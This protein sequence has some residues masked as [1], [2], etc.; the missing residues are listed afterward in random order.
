LETHNRPRVLETGLGDILAAEH[1]GYTGS[2]RRF[3]DVDPDDLGVGAVG[4]QEVSEQLPG[5]LPVRRIAAASGDQTE[6]LAAA[7]EPFSHGC[8]LRCS[9]RRGE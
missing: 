4:A 1:A 6:I 3:G 9:F 8:S 5:P 7:F 2:R